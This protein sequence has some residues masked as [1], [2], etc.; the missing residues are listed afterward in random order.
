MWEK[1]KKT[2][3]HIYRVFL[4]LLLLVFLVMIL[5]TLM[6]KDLRL[7]TNIMSIISLVVVVLSLPGIINTL[8]E[9]FNPKKKTYKLSS[10]CPNCKHLIEMDMKEE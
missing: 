2:L 7:N 3:N 10:K 5:V 6:V 8:T 9:E 4:A 1:I